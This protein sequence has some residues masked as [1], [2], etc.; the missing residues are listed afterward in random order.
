MCVAFSRNFEVME[1]TKDEKDTIEQF[2]AL[3][4]A[5]LDR[6]IVRAGS[7]E[8]GRRLAERA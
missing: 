2:G 4:C 1:E 5:A 3:G 7:D 8:A 6:R